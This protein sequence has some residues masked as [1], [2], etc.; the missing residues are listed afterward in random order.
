MSMPNAIPGF[1]MYVRRTKSPRISRLL[2][3]RSPWRCRPR[4]GRLTPLTT[5]F[6]TWSATTTKRLRNSMR[7]RPA[8]F[9]R[10]DFA[11]EALLGVRHRLEALLLDELLARDAAAVLPL[12]DPDERVLE[13]V[14]ELALARGEQECLLA[15]HGVGPLLHV[16]RV[17]RVLAGVLPGRRIHHRIAQRFELFE[18][19]LLLLENDLLEMVEVLLAVL[20]LLHGGLRRL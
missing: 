8:L 9:L 13:I 2:P 19:L 1:S 18:D 6:V 12:L 17:H 3:R 14:E 15:F 4:N 5:S 7:T 16:R 20:L 10:A 11:L